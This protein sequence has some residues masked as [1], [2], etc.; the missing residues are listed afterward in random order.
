MLQMEIWIEASTSEDLVIS[1][2]PDFFS[3]K[4]M[5]LHV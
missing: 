1:L 5:P 3:M 4:N 2:Q